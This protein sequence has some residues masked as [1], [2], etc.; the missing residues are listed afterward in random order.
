M[1]TGEVDW[2]GAADAQ[3]QHDQEVL[4]RSTHDVGFKYGQ[5]FSDIESVNYR[6][7]NN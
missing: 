1:A 2:A 6:L 7:T 3:V 5:A 4:S